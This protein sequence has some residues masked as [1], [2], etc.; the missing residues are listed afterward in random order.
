MRPTLLTVGQGVA[1]YIFQFAA[2]SLCCL[3]FTTIR[4]IQTQSQL[5]KKP[6]KEQS[7]WAVSQYTQTLSKQAL[8]LVTRISFIRLRQ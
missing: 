1:V 3:P 6:Q 2:A 4:K 5:T 7:G 8:V